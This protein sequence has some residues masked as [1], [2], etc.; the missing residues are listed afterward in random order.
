LFCVDAA[1]IRPILTEHPIKNLADVATSEVLVLDTQTT[2]AEM[3]EHVLAVA[4]QR[5]SIAGH[6]LGG[7]IAQEIAARAP[8]PV[9]KLFRCDT[10][11]RKL[12]GTD[13]YLHSYWTHAERSSV[14]SRD[15]TKP[16]PGSARRPAWPLVKTQQYFDM[17]RPPV[18]RGPICWGR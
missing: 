4:P 8:E 6:S 16:R 7:W 3:A 2:M 13:E 18:G 1:A 11:A 15:V 17:N 9:A 14:E 12:D 10:W 5:V